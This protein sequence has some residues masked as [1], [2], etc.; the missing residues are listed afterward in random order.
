MKIGK[1]GQMQ[2]METVGV[3]FIFFVLILFAAIFY[4]KFSQSSFEQYQEELVAQTAMDN[5]LIALFLPELQCSQ[6]EAEAEDNCVDLLKVRELVTIMEAHSND[7]Y[8]NLFGFS[9]I[10]VNMVYPEQHSWIIYDREKVSINDEGETVA[11]WTRKEPTYFIVALR[12]YT[13]G[14][15]EELYSYDGVYSFGYLAVEVYS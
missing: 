15:P 12:D 5:T 13:L 6:G 11:S 9:K 2:M 1:H 3:I 14:G 7:Y 8:F 4:F 10:S